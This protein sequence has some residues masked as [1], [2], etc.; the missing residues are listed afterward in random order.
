MKKNDEIKTLRKFLEDV[1][2]PNS[3]HSIVKYKE[4]AVCIEKILKG[5]LC[6][7]L[8]LNNLSH[9]CSLDG[10]AEESVCMEKEGKEY[11]VYIG[12]RNNKY[13]L[14]KY[15]KIIPAFGDIISRLSETDKEETK[16]KRE[17]VKM[18]LNKLQ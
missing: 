12:E 5:T 4:D 18:L 8:K 7:V 6:K 1:G 11:I 9:L 3:Y 14:R 10:Y 2:I 15:T 17:F 13:D 16:L